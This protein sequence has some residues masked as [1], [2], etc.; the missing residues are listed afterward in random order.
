MRNKTLSNAI[1]LEKKF[2]KEFSTQIMA[3]VLQ[4][5]VNQSW[6]VS[7]I[8]IATKNEIWKEK[9]TK[10]QRRNDMTG[11][12][13]QEL[14]RCSSTSQ[15]TIDLLNKLFFNYTVIGMTC[16]FLC[17]VLNKDREKVSDSV[18]S[19]K[20]CQFVICFIKSVSLKQVLSMTFSIDLNTSAR[21]LTN[22]SINQ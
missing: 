8:F 16:G 3:N 9:Q 21:F 12:S 19:V 22:T 15:L 7:S 6:C 2:L 13:V 20:S 10:M 1:E 4:I 5:T 18:I 11:F 14:R 17:V